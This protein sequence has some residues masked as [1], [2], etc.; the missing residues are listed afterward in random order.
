MST[1]DITLAT[2]QSVWAWS[3]EPVSLLLWVFSSVVHKTT[4]FDCRLSTLSLVEF[5]S[6][7]LGLSMTLYT[8]ESYTKQYNSVIQLESEDTLFFQVALQT[9][10]TFASDVLLQV[11]SCWA[12]ESIHPDDA[13]QGVLLQDGLVKTIVFVA[14]LDF[15]CVQK[16]FDTFTPESHKRSGLFSLLILGNVP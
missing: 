11:D 4:Y 6:L 16:H 9:N 3:G 12:T 5:S 14:E 13:V 1:L 7:Q 8:N 2:L 15:K 10:N